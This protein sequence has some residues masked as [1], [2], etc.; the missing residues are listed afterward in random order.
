MFSARGADR[1]VKL[2]D[3]GW[4]FVDAKSDRLSAGVSGSVER[5]SRMSLRS[6][7]GDQPAGIA[8]CVESC[9][10]GKTRAVLG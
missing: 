3:E 6:A 4:G 10:Q 7:A 8:P 5:N 2:A 1:T 9:G